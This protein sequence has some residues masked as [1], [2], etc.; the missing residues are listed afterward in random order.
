ME[1]LKN[2]LSAMGTLS[3]ADMPALSAD[4]LML[5]AAEMSRA[6]ARQLA[7]ERRAQK[8]VRVDGLLGRTS[9]PRRFADA[10]LLEPGAQLGAYR[11]AEDFRRGFVARLRDGAGL[12]IWGDVGTG[13]THLACALANAL[14]SDGYSAM[15]LTALE[16]VSMVR[17]SW[18]RDSPVSEL[19]VYRGFVEPDLLILDELGVQCDTDFER[20]VLTTI[21]DAR[22]R[23]CR[24]VVAVSNLAPPALYELLGVRMFDRLVGFGAGIVCL[25]GQSLRVSHG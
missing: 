14:L 20:V 4:E 21:A 6:A 13:K 7:D 24:P 8:Q 25:Q 15:Y 10:S 22:S 11:Q 18:R 3:S 17:A 12:V 1:S 16:A 5:Q 9:V 23:E 2:L 19:A